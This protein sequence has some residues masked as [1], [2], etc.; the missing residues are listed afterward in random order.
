VNAWEFFAHMN[1]PNRLTFLRILAVPL[2]M[3]C[4]L[5]ENVWG[6]ALALLVFIGAAL[7]DY[8]DGKLA[9]ERNLVTNFGRIMDPLADKLL[10]A[11][12]FICFVQMG[13][14]PAW[15]VILI[16]GREF[17]ITGLRILGAAQGRI[18]AASD[19]GKHKTVSQIVAVLL[20]LTINILVCGL[21]AWAPP[22][23]YALI[24]LGWRGEVLLY[25]IYYAPY[26]G[27]LTSALLSLY[28]GVEYLVANRELFREP[29]S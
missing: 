8:W 3:A 10:M 18:I 9:R 22:W 16:I 20:I 2:L 23:E 14:A 21:R 7:T 26:A 11:T 5:W 19:S 13:Y 27:M 12:A 4:L 17:A 25:T 1:L 28:S 6:A 29:A 24:T 15:M